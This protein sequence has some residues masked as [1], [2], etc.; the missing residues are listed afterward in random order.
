MQSFNRQE[1][2]KRAELRFPNQG[3]RDRNRKYLVEITIFRNDTKLLKRRTSIKSQYEI[4][5]KD[6]ILDLTFILKEVMRINHHITNVQIKLREK[7]HTMRQKRSEFQEFQESPEIF[8]GESPILVIFTKNKAFLENML[9]SKMG[10]IPQ[11]HKEQQQEQDIIR[12]VRHKRTTGRYRLRSNRGRCK[13]Y[14]FMIDFDAVGWGDHV[15]YPKR[16]N[17]YHCQGRCPSPIEESYNPTNH[18]ILQSIARLSNKHI[19]SPCCIPTKLRPVSMLY[20]ENREIVL[21]HHEDM[22]AENCGCR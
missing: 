12:N 13:R 9:N 4:D 15:I 14:D 3:K 8:S 11:V 17:A 22:V 16:F 5:N 1:E 2:I 20:Y 18:A 21:R 10:N 19:P 7:R 6:I